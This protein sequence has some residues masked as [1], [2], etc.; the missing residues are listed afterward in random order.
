MAF[1]TYL[2]M[3]IITRNIVNMATIDGEG[4]K[5][6]E[7]IKDIFDDVIVMKYLKEGELV[8]TMSA[9]ERNQIL[10]QQTKKFV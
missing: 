8:A 7:G 6:F 2:N 5:E 9:K 10:Q 1:S 3:L 4:G